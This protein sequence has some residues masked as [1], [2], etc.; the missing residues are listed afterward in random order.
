MANMSEGLA[1]TVIGIGIVFAVLVILWGFIACMQ[2]VFAKGKAKPE[3]DKANANTAPAETKAEIAV[4]NIAEDENEE[5]IVAVIM[6]AIAN[7]LNTSTYN[8]NIK[9]IRRVG[10]AAPAWNAASR[11]EN[12]ENQI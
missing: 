6:A 12:V 5:E 9:S 1:I 11:R 4:S 2:L 7:C 8:L 3:G 10:N